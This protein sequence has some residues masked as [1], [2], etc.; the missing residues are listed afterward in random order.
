MA[1]CQGDYDNRLNRSTITPHPP[2]P[3]LANPYVY[4]YLLPR[5]SIV[6]RLLLSKVPELCCLSQLV[7]HTPRYFTTGGPASG[8]ILT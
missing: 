8:M 4:R 1:V 2:V 6:N 5:C 7:N 3:S